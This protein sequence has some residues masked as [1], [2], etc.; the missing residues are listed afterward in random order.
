MMPTFKIS[1]IAGAN[2]FGRA[3]TRTYIYHL[4]YHRGRTEENNMR[5][6]KPK[7]ENYEQ[8]RKKIRLSTSPS[9]TLRV[10]ADHRTTQLLKVLQRSRCRIVDPISLP[11]NKEE[12]T[13]GFDKCNE[14]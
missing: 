10:T 9:N 13:H 14:T 12:E 7:R 8:Q 6:A 11:M 5:S 2:M 1:M 3:V 4:I